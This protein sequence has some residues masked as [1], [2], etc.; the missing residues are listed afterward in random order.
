MCAGGGGGGGGGGGVKGARGEGGEVR[1]G[2]NSVDDT[3]Y[4]S[5]MHWLSEFL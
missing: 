1:A 2:R 3:S 5:A 4:W